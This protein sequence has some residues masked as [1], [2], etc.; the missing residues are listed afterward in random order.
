LA[1]FL[2]RVDVDSANLGSDLEPHALYLSCPEILYNRS[3][4]IENGERIC[5]VLPVSLSESPLL[6]YALFASPHCFFV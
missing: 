6:T 5:D 1:P 4:F 3:L 2:R